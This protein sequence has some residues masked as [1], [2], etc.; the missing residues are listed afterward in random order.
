MVIYHISDEYNLTVRI[1]DNATSQTVETS[2]S[3]IIVDSY[4]WLTDFVF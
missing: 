1:Q 4:F 2:E 3:L